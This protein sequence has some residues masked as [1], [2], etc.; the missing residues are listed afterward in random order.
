[1]RINKEIITTEFGRLVNN[2]FLLPEIISVKGRDV[3]I[4]NNSDRNDKICGIRM[5][6]L[7]RQTIGNG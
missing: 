7:H 5:T 2:V 3:V 6:R 1:M 4:E